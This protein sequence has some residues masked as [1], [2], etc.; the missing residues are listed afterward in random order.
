MLRNEDTQKKGFVGIYY[1]TSMNGNIFDP[2]D[3]DKYVKLWTFNNSAPI[4]HASM[5]VCMKTNHVPWF[6]KTMLNMQKSQSIVRTKFHS[7]SD[8][9][10]IYNLRSYGIEESSFPVSSDGKVRNAIL[11]NWLDEHKYRAGYNT[12]FTLSPVSYT[13]LTLPT[14][15][16]V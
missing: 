2:R 1:D 14:K 5:H 9:E 3:I 8:M 10:I 11:N 13:H 7:G 15:R 6:I 4:R 12:P 16:I